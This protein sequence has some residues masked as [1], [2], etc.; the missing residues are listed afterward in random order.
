MADI[1]AVTGSITTSTR[2]AR[3]LERLGCL[4]ARVVHT[5]S[6]ISSGGCSYCVRIPEECITELL[7]L[8][9]KR[10]MKIK[11]LYRELSDGEER[12]YDDIS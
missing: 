5:P 7:A 11:K 1:L 12:V 8:R 6:A 2:L 9:K 10:S 3:E 4:K